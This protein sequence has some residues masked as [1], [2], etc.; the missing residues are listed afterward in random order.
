MITKNDK[1]NTDNKNDID[2]K[3]NKDNKTING[4]INKDKFMD[5]MI[6]DLS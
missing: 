3:D 6:D 5:H 1:N 4:N 2:K